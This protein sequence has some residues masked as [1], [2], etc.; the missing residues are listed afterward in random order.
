MRLTAIGLGMVFVI[1]LASIGLT[2]DAPDAKTIDLWP[3]TAPGEN[4]TIGEE[5]TKTRGEGDSKVVTSITN[6]TKPTITVSRPD[7]D[8]N[9]GVAIVV[10]PGG[11]YNNL[12]WEHEGTMVARWLNSIGVTAAVLKYRV[13]RR[14][15]TPKEQQPVQALMDA[16]R[17]L[18]LVRSRADEWGIDPKKVGI[19]GFSAGGHLGAWASTNYDKRAYDA[20][21]AA[22]KV[23]IRPDFAVLIYPGAVTRRGTDQINDNIRI[24]S[25]TPP[26]FLACATDD[27]LAESNVALYLALKRAGVPVEMHLYSKGKHGFGMRESDNPHSTWPQSCEKWLRAEKVLAPASR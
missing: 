25:Q 12:A 27:G 3:G 1:G 4:G 18:S 26:T 9:T 15:D 19:M 8:K 13:P 16:Q 22:D 14:P 23:D 7:R 11:G 17:A 24:T 6:V 10:C 5:Q 21:D 2:A 20:V